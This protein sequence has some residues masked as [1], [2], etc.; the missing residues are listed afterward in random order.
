M[1]MPRARGGRSLTR[2]SAD[3]DVAGARLVEPGDQAQERGLAAARRAE[4]HE[5]LAV[6]DVEV[7]ID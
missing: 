3:A 2:L 1:A 5:E 7:D 6:G 4:Q